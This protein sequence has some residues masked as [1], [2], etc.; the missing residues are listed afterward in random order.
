[1]NS[2]ASTSPPPCFTSP[3]DGEYPRCDATPDCQPSV[4]GAINVSMESSYLNRAK[5]MV[6]D[7]EPGIIKAV[8]KH[9]RGIGCSQLVTTTD[10]SQ[11]LE[12]IRNEQPDLIL[13]DI[14][15]PQVTGLELLRLVRAESQ[16]RHLP[17]IILTAHADPATKREALEAGATDFLGKPVDATS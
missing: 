3:S 1:M 15:M 5:I 11:A 14:M 8:A 10:S 7:D 6:V 17:V 16:L 13:L 4:V 9:L 12:L 2:M